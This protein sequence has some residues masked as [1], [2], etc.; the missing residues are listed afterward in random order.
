MSNHRPHDNDD[1]HYEHIQHSDVHYENRDLGGRG[2]IIFMVGLLVVTGFLMLVVAGTMRY[3]NQ[4]ADFMFPGAPALSSIQKPAP[5]V[6]PA[7]RFP[8]PRLQTDDVADMDKLRSDNFGILNSYGW[9]DK[10][11]N[12]VHV[13]ISRAIDMVAEQGLPVRT[14]PNIAPAAD[15]G[16]GS[17]SLAGAGGGTRPESSH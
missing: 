15:F 10:A 11:S 6:D 9:V 8:E 2:V 7:M 13:P 14:D 12:V 3:F 5:A 1:I 4:A 16:S 17:K